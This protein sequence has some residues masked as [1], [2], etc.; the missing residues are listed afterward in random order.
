MDLSEPWDNSLDI[1]ALQSVK[2]NTMYEP[3]VP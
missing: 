2:N 3:N 1:V